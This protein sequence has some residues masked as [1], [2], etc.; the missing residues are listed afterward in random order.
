MKLRDQPRHVKL[1]A[2]PKSSSPTL[3]QRF[4]QLRPRSRWFDGLKWAE[5]MS[6]AGHSPDGIQTELLFVR[7]LSKHFIEGVAD[8]LNFQFD[9]NS[10]F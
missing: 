6:Q 2:N 5:A 8:Y 10:P 4:H 3:R 9:Q 1:I 7:N